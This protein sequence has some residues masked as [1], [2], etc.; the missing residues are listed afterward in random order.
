MAWRKKFSNCF[1]RL[2]STSTW[3]RLFLSSFSTLT[4]LKPRGHCVGWIFVC[5]LSVQNRAMPNASQP[6]AQVAVPANSNHK[7]WAITLERGAS[8]RGA[9]KCRRYGMRCYQFG[10]SNFQ[11]GTWRNLLR[12][13]SK[14]CARTLLLRLVV[15][16]IVAK[17]NTTTTKLLIA[18]SIWMILV[19][20]S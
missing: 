11:K 14:S 13:R 4:V 8:N 19:R 17:S 10:D 16:D 7:L 2:S 12:P 5:P 6:P 20:F 1:F 18:C 9:P 15:V 3:W